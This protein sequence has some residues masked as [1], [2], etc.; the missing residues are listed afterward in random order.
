MPLFEDDA[1][2]RLRRQL[3]FAALATKDSTDTESETDTDSET[4]SDSE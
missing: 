1:D 2:Q 4:E 3:Q